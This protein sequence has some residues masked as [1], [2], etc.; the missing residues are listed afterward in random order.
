MISVNRLQKIRQLN[1]WNKKEGAYAPSFYVYN[2]FTLFLP[3][4]Q[5]IPLRHA[6]LVD[7]QIMP[8]VV[9]YYDEIV[10]VFT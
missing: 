3:Y 10:D 4:M 2:N 1:L 7:C 8:K 9:K 5:M 6:Y